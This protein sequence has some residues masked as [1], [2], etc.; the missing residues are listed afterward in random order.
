MLICILIQS[1]C[2]MYILHTGLCCR[3]NDVHPPFL[4]HYTT[5]DENLV[6]T[7]TQLPRSSL[8]VRFHED[9]PYEV[10]K[11][12]APHEWTV[13]HPERSWPQPTGSVVKWQV[14]LR[15]SAGSDRERGREEAEGSNFQGFQL[16]WTWKPPCHSHGPHSHHRKIP[17]TKHADYALFTASIE[18]WG[19]MNR[20]WA[21]LERGNLTST[22]MGSML[23]STEKVKE[24]TE[25]NPWENHRSIIRNYA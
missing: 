5:G 20:N 12:A 24:L 13:L 8:L 2:V 4:I 22:V 1:K 23:E 16:P 19:N 3:R 17:E 6:K 18:T 15:V 7:D 14:L 9:G 10:A 25:T 21:W 11:H